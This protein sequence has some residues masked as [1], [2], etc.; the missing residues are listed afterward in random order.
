MRSRL[1]FL[2]RRRLGVNGWMVG[3][4]IPKI[5]IRPHDGTVTRPG[6]GGVV[7]P[8]SGFVIRP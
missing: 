1:F 6:T 2:R 7:R 8:F 4:G 5:V 3:S